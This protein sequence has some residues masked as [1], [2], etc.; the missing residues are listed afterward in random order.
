[1]QP[2]T[3]DRTEDVKLSKALPFAKMILD[4]EVRQGLQKANYIYPTTLQATTISLGRSGKG[5]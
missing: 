4:Q 3:N 5:K 1:M 2:A